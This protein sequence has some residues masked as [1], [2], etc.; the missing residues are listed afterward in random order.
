MG[1][2]DDSPT[3]PLPIA[4]ASAKEESNGDVKLSGT[5]GGWRRYM[6]ARSTGPAALNRTHAMP[7]AIPGGNPYG[8]INGSDRLAD[9]G[10]KSRSRTPPALRPTITR[11]TE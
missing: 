10:E 5:R 11:S 1:A 6:N 8:V 3:P 7:S 9:N 2:S 4:S